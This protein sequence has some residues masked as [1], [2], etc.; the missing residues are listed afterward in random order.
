MSVCM[1][2]ERYSF[3]SDDDDDSGSD[4]GGLE[5]LEWGEEEDEVEDDSDEGEEG[6]GDEEVAVNISGKPGQPPSQ[7]ANQAGSQPARQPSA[8]EY[9]LTP[10][11]ASLWM[12]SVTPSTAHACPLTPCA[13]R[14]LTPLAPA[15]V[16]ALA[17][18]ST[19]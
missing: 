12:P 15:P 1:T 19:P 5:A 9:F 14:T 6:E 16:P 13:R 2:G 3:G 10:A 17:S 18:V 4:G 11:A 8:A 7:P